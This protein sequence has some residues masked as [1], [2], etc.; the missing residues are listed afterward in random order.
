MHLSV[1]LSVLSLIP[2]SVYVMADGNSFAFPFGSLPL[3]IRN[4]T[5]KYFIYNDLQTLKRISAVRI[6]AMEKTNE[7]YQALLS[8]YYD[9]SAHYYGLSET[10]LAL[11]DKIADLL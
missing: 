2:L 8:S 4:K 5:L 7:I 9:A 10:D 3:V 1:W 11:V 6:Q